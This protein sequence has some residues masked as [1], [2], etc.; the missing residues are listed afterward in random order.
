V[1]LAVV[2]GLVTSTTLFLQNRASRHVAEEQRDRILRLSDANVLVHLN[3]TAQGLRPPHPD[4]VPAM[5]AWLEEADELAA[6]LPVHRETLAQ[7]RRSARSEPATPGQPPRLVFANQQDEFHHEHLSALVAG[8]EGFVDPDPRVGTIARVRDRLAF[9]SSVVEESVTQH[10]AE[11]N[12]AIRSIANV[13]TC[14]AYGGLVI[15]PQVGLV[16]VGRDPQSGL[17]EF[18]HLRTGAIPVRDDR[19]RLIVTGE[20]GVVL[21][22][23]P[24]GCY[25][26]GMAKE[27]QPDPAMPGGDPLARLD[28][29]PVHRVCLDPF[30]MSKYEVTQA[31]YL[32]VTG[33]NPSRVHPGLDYRM[34]VTSLLHPVEDLNWD[35]ADNFARD[36]GLV[37]PSEA[38]WEYAARAGS[39]A[40]FPCGWD[41][42][43]LHGTE[44]I[45]DE[46]AR[47]P[48]RPGGWSYAPWHDGF[49]DS[50]P[51]GFYAPNAFG[52]HDVMGNV[53]EW[54]GDWYG[55]Y[56]LPVGAGDGR[57]LGSERGERV[58]RGGGFYFWPERVSV[59]LRLNI[60]PH[61]NDRIGMR[62]ARPVDSADTVAGLAPSR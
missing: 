55:S 24:G 40:R 43:C 14:P 23:L 48:A 2:L 38:Q 18:V 22:L 44:N 29:V 19:G 46:S 53:T 8:L 26:M 57:R 58:V 12:E 28:E 54:T 39:T 1:A 34:Y 4:R 56:Q 10:R 31:Q 60:P 59:S 27:V 16:P 9:A 50:S 7:L 51:V 37:L 3:D 13:E 61:I 32:R 36:V 17:W 62:P 45:L 20:T 21:V 15:A 52:L 42:A 33:R 49:V 47:V 5:T 6:R 35:M 41:P 30:F 25:W 11:W